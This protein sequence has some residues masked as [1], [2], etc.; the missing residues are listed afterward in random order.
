M[1]RALLLL[2]LA[3][4]LSVSPPAEAKGT[5]RSPDFELQT[6][7]VTGAAPADGEPLSESAG[8]TLRSRLGGPFV[9][10]AESPSFALW[11]CGAY[12]PVEAWMFIEEALEELV[13]LRWNVESLGGAV[14]F[15][16]ARRAP[17]G[18]RPGTGRLSAG[19]VAE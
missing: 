3:V 4:A 6:W 8:F 13:V 9:G 1:T 11:G 15:A 12:T 10:H 16:E 5:A 19:A 14:G 17:A 18:S 7:A 2:F